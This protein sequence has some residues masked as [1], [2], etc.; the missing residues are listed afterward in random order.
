MIIGDIIKGHVNEMLGLNVDISEAR[1]HIC[2]KCPLY[3]PKL[4][5]I[6]NHDLWLN[7][8]TGDTSTEAK[9]GYIRGCG[10]RIKAKTTLP[11]S[12]CPAH[13]W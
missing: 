10:C 2:V 11:Y 5:G 3:L 8:D 6:C 1:T 7:P 9:D 12:S 13:K 4:G